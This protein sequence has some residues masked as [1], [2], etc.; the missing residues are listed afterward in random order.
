MKVINDLKTLI[1][2]L[3]KKT[4]TY[5]NRYLNEWGNIFAYHTSEKRRIFKV[6]NTLIK[7]N[8]KNLS[9]LLKMSKGA[10]EKL[11]QRIQLAKVTINIY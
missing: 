9:K 2:F 10:K 8:K 4:T 1:R 5:A 3:K 7:H 11:S 6:H